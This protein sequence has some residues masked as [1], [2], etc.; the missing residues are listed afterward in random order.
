[1]NRAAYAVLAAGAIVTAAASYQLKQLNRDI[2]QA[3]LLYA[4]MEEDHS[5]LVK[6]V[7]NVSDRLAPPR[8]VVQN[9]TPENVEALAQALRYPG[10]TGGVIRCNGCGN[11]IGDGHPANCPIA[12]AAPDIH[13]HRLGAA[14]DAGSYKSEQINEGE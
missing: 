1:M 10:A 14:P 11:K 6:M 12:G 9:V 13:D 2:R 7:I 4:Q 3:R 5:Q 8:K